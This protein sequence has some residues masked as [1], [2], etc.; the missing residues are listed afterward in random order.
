MSERHISM[1]VRPAESTVV[2]SVDSVTCLS[3]YDERAGSGARLDG[4]HLAAAAAV[5]IDADRKVVHPRHTAEVTVPH[6]APALLAGH[7]IVADHFAPVGGDHG[8]GGDH[9]RGGARAPRSPQL[10]QVG[11]HAARGT[12]GWRG[13]G[14][15]P[16]HRRAHAAVPP[17][18][19]RRRRDDD[20][21][22]RGRQYVALGAALG[23]D[24]RRG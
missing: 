9:R 19:R 8:A 13:H 14:G 23:L 6:E 10:P 11:G 1:R 3:A 5:G 21:D 12:D 22:G 17:D 7:R 15:P 4:A 24:Q 2:P 20:S 18:Q 16:D